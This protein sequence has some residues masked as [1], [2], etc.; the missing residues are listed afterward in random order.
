VL[1]QYAKDVYPIELS[2]A[3]LLIMNRVLAQNPNLSASVQPFQMSGSDQDSETSLIGS[4][5]AAK[6]SSGSG[7]RTRLIAIDAFAKI[8]NLSIGFMQADVEAHAFPVIKGGWEI[9]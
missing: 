3:N 6:I 1:S 2:E 4:G 7:E 5:E 8:Y 9:L